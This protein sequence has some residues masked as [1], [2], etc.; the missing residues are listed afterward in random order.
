MLHVI[1]DPTFTMPGVNVQAFAWSE[2]GDVARLQKFDIG[3]YPLPMKRWVLGKSA[4]K[5]LQY[6]AVGVPVVATPVGTTL[7]VV[8]DGE[9]GYF[10]E[11]DDEWESRILALMRDPALRQRM[12]D[13]GR[14]LVEQH[15]SV[16]GT[17][18][19]YRAV[20]ERVFRGSGQVP[21]YPYPAGGDMVHLPV[22]P[23]PR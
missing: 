15:Y 3:L 20:L 5:A 16:A 7:R 17:A 14:A 18:P 19:L 4:V 6:L 21:S 23:R 9:N 8:V 10:A 2:A 1:G 13:T 12:G 22:E 11:T